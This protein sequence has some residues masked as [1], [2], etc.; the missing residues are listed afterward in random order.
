MLAIQIVVAVAGFGALMW[1]M[2]AWM[3]R[4]NRHERELMERRR[5]E[6]IANGSDPDDEPNFYTGFGGGS[7]G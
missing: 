2:V 6:W 5:S 7:G 4:A 3:I 1:A